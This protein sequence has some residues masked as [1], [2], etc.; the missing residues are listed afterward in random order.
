MKKRAA[1]AAAAAR[2]ANVAAENSPVSPQSPHEHGPGC[3]D[4]HHHH[5]EGGDGELRLRAVNA[6]FAKRL[7]DTR[8]ELAAVK[9]QLAAAGI[10]QA[11]PELAAELREAREQISALKSKLAL[12]DEPEPKRSPELCAAREAQIVSERRAAA[13][14]AE[15]AR[16]RAGAPDLLEACRAREAQVAA[17]ERAAELEKELA[18]ARA[19]AAAAGENEARLAAAEDALACAAAASPPD[20]SPSGALAARRAAES[21]VAALEKDLAKA[22]KAAAEANRVSVRVAELEARLA[23]TDEELEASPC[24]PNVAK[25]SAAPFGNPDF[26]TGDE[27]PWDQGDTRIKIV[28][29]TVSMA[30]APRVPK[31]QSVFGR[32]RDFVGNT[33]GFFAMMFGKVLTGLRNAMPF[34]RATRNE[35]TPLLC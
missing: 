8:D 24:T 6:L 34:G 28:S 23:S 10:G 31:H 19:T 27:T 13:L 2:F 14:E 26:E 17:E 3:A 12:N 18:A 32:F 30:V 4:G 21:R 35:N 25:R 16:A 1:A 7:A 33:I 29:G 11:E 22:E 5:D 9:A 15:L 20:S